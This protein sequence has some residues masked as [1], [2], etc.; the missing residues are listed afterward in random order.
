MFSDLKKERTEARIRSR[1]IYADYR[2]IAAADSATAFQ[3]P[4][5]TSFPVS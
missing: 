5:T 1:N 4:L 2:V 3:T